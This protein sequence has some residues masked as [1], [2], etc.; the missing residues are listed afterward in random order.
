MYMS[1]LEKNTL[2]MAI[3]T[4][5]ST[6]VTQLAEL[7]GDEASH[8]D[9]YIAG[10]MQGYIHG[11]DMACYAIDHCENIEFPPKATCAVAHEQPEGEARP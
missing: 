3:T 1:E 6:A 4:T 9:T 2:T 11:A 5:S 10:Y 8:P 7:A